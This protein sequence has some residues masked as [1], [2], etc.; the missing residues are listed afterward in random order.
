MVARV[1]GL[2]RF[3][4]ALTT[5]QKVVKQ[6]K[7]KGLL[8]GD[9]TSPAKISPAA[10]AGTGSSGIENGSPHRLGLVVTDITNPFFSRV[11]RYIQ[12]AAGD[13]GYQVLMSGSDTD[14][15]R[16]CKIIEGLL[17]I[18]V[19]GL[20]ICPGMDDVCAAFYR[21]LI[22]RGV[23]IS[24]VSR[25]IQGVEADFV[26]AHNFAG[27]ALAAGH[28]LSMGCDS[29]GYIGFG[30]RLKNDKR[31]HGFRSALMEEGIDFGPD[32]I[33]GSNGRDIIHGYRAMR[34][35]MQ[36]ADRPRAVFAYNDL[37]AIGTLQ[38]CLEHDIAVP[39]EVALVGFDNLPESRVTNPPLTSV[40]YPIQSIARLAVQNI[41][42]RI[43]CVG[44]R[45][46]NQIFL[47]PHLVVRQ[48]TD[49]RV[50]ITDTSTASETD[51]SE[52]V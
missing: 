3:G 40:A 29:F 36:G 31:L 22:D 4:I 10:F 1:S 35:L 15:H 5:A 48:S 24:F 14:F 20:L 30:P 51:A 16:E 33:A 23:R 19:E 42:D 28:L 21:S 27:G 38:Y 8:I 49:P 44:D 34:H 43:Q 26:V 6:L 39:G 17:E 13:Q 37:L 41:V 46:P 32:R 52:I 45:P 2:L 25:H 9:S 12:R 50:K 47:E 11:C 18:G 7:D